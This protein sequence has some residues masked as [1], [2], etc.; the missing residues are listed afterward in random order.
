MDGRIVAPKKIDSD[1]STDIAVLEVPD[2]KLVGARFGDS[3]RVEIADLSWRRESIQFDTIG[4]LGDRERQRPPRFGPQ[5]RG[6]YPGLHPNRRGDQPWQLGRT[7]RDSTRRDYWHEHR[8]RQPI[9]R[10]RR[11]RLCHPSNIVL[12]IAKHLIEKGYVTRGYL[13]VTLDHKYTPA[14]AA[15]LGLPRVMGA[16]VLCDAEVPAEDAKFLLDDVI[17][18]FKRPAD[19]Q[20]Y[21]SGQPD[22]LDRSRQASPVVIWRI[23]EQQTI[24]VVLS[25]RGKFDIKK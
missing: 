3:D 9:R 5:R 1:K 19:R 23:G 12:N 6:R 16:R 22:W 24:Q 2:D 4:D 18:Q 11:R 8:H 21:A 15:K 13:G 14:I 10:R 20:R 7:A 25:D 17:L